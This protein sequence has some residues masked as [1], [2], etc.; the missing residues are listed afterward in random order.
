MILADLMLFLDL[1][2]RGSAQIAFDPKLSDIYGCLLRKKGQHWK[3]RWCV[4]RDDVFY[5]YRDSGYTQEDFKCSLRKCNVVSNSQES[6]RANAFQLVRRRG[7]EFLLA[8]EDCSELDRWLP[9][10]QRQTSKHCLS[11]GL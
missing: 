6:S 10:L 5:A 7:E 11:E 9:V 4:V 3:L 2:R 8:A 1:G